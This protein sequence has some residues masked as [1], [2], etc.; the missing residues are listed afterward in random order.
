VIASD[1]P[2]SNNA[3]ASTGAEPARLATTTKVAIPIVPAT[4]TRAE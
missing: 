4:A 1:A 2:A 3:P